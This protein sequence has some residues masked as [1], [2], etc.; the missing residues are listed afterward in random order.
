MSAKNAPPTSARAW[1]VAKLTSLKFEG[2]ADALAAYVDALVENNRETESGDPV[3][4]REQVTTDLADFLGKETAEIFVDALM[5][6]LGGDEGDMD[7]EKG[8]TVPIKETEVLKEEG[9][10]IKGGKEAGRKQSV[11]S[12]LGDRAVEPGR[13][14]T[15]ER[16]RA[17]ASPRGGWR[18]RGDRDRMDKSDGRSRERGDGR[19]DRMDRDKLEREPGDYREQVAVRDRL[20]PASFHRANKRT[21]EPDDD[22]R[23]EREPL[24]RRG[25]SGERRSGEGR[26]SG[27]GGRGDGRK[28]D[29]KM[30]QGVPPPFGF[31]P[32]MV[33]PEMMMKFPP[34]PFPPGMMP[35]HPLIP[36]AAVMGRQGRGGVYNG[37]GGRENRDRGGRDRGRGWE[38]RD[39]ENRGKEGRGNMQNVGAPRGGALGAHEGKGGRG[40]YSV[41]AMRNVPEDKLKLPHILKFF[42]MYGTPDNVQL[43]TPDRAFI[44]YASREPALAAV[45]SVDAIMGNRHIKLGWATAMDYEIANLELT[46]DGVLKPR[47]NGRP[48]NDRKNEKSDRREENYKQENNT[49][50]GG[51]KNTDKEK[52]ERIEMDADA[53][54]E[55]QAAAQ[56]L[57]ER[58]RKAAEEDLRK[59]R[60]AIAEA[61][62]KQEEEKASL[63]A[64]KKQLVEDQKQLFLEMEA[65]T[66]QGVKVDLLRKAK[67][68]EAELKQVVAGLNP[69]AVT[70]RQTR[71]VEAN[72]R[73]GHTNWA[74]RGPG[75]GGNA[76]SG[77]RF[78]DF[79]VDNRPK[80]LQIMGAT[81][82]IT[83]DNAMSVFHDTV[84]AERVGGFW[85][86]RFASRKAAE[87]ALRAR[88]PLKRG[89]GTGAMAQIIADSEGTRHAVAELENTNEG[90]E[91][92]AMEG[93]NEGEQDV[94]GNGV[95]SQE[96]ERNAM[97]ID[98][99]DVAVR[100]VSAQATVE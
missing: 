69:N 93:G 39:N 95:G 18:E 28:N 27:P 59:K 54:A 6:Y 51:T 80:T 46:E 89:F 61:R 70:A 100:P 3:L 37:H 77:D 22:R 7:K 49:D 90:K 85:L 75:R 35:P 88:G 36:P 32:P 1:S 12:R 98:S 14:M 8:A 76:S 71:T 81:T 48:K 41:L 67:S 87:S 2:D 25:E 4:L 50:V 66:E 97:I 86:L 29:K 57:K 24:R 23:G 34:P 91:S 40:K 64:R 74:G 58:K 21:R 15:R 83:V 10:G 11:I 19:L 63:Q 43:V 79:S 31:P 84:G 65:A 17:Y 44:I 94:V 30:V 78:K 55:A 20:G 38:G 72:P 13:G 99:D 82:G 96:D 45:K 26:H 52:T 16:P 60:Q 56:E 33:T 42:E 73:G 5:K 62:A 53:Q 92:E 47:T 68:I 9:A